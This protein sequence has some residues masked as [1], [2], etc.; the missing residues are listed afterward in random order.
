M[1]LISEQIEEIKI[2]TEEGREGKKVG[3]AF[4]IG[5]KD[6]LKPYLKQLIINPIKKAKTVG[7]KILIKLISIYR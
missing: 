1:K 5:D 6:L 2:I 7:I 4:I 3:T